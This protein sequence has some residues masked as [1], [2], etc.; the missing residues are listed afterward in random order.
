MQYSHPS[1]TDFLSVSYLAQSVQ[2]QRGQ[3]PERPTGTT[4]KQFRQKHWSLGLLSP[5]PLLLIL[6]LIA[7]FYYSLC[8]NCESSEIYVAHCDFKM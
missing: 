8:F 6:P 1:I 4:N 2:R 7:E 3:E 5:F